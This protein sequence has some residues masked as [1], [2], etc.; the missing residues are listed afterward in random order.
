MKIEKWQ[1]ILLSMVF[2]Y[3]AAA[4]CVLTNKGICTSIFFTSFCRLDSRF[5]W[6]IGPVILFTI[7]VLLWGKELA[8]Q[9]KKIKIIAM[10][11][12]SFFAIFVL[13]YS[14]QTT[15]FPDICN[16]ATAKKFIFGKLDETKGKNWNSNLSMN[17]EEF[18]YRT[19]DDIYNTGSITYDGYKICH[20]RNKIFQ[21]GKES[22]DIYYYYDSYLKKYIEFKPEDY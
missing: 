3:I 5:L 16:E 8:S 7:L 13:G 20:I 1:K 21:F 4:I 11:S 14:L 15:F 9:S 18:F 6:M 12:L 17:K 2:L 22:Q 19:F 10:I